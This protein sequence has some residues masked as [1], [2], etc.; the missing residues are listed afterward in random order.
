MKKFLMLAVALAAASS[1]TK[2]AQLCASGESIFGLTV[3]PG[4]TYTST[5]SCQLGNTVFSNFSVVTN[6]GFPATSLFNLALSVNTGGGELDFGVTLSAGEDLRLYYQIASGVD[7]MTMSVAG[8][9]STITETACSQ[10]FTGVVCGGTVLADFAASSNQTVTS[11]FSEIVPVD[12]IFKDIQAGSGLSDFTQTIIP[13]P[14]TLS[15]MGA[16]LLGLGILG[17]RRMKK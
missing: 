1:V 15:L 17:R 10:A 7:G 6:A 13:E 16:G 9:G 8:T 12:Y 4:Q 3:T 14:M 11:A 2:A 5:F